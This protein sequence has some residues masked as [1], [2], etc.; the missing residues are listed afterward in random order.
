MVAEAVGGWPRAGVPGGPGE[1]GWAAGAG[2]E[3]APSP[4]SAGG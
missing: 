4:G 2:G 3:P 1:S